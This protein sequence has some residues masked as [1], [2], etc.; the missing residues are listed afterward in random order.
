MISVVYCT[1]KTSPEHKEH[2]IKSSGLHKK[3]EVIEIINNG[4]S[5]TKAYNRGLK[6]AN[7]NIV[8]FC[9][10]DITIE[11]KNWGEKLLKQLKN[12]PEY[13]I[14][15]VAGTKYLPQ[16]GRW[17]EKPQKMYGRVQHTH[18][19]KTWLSSY[20]DDLGLDLEQVVLVDGLFFAVDKT[21][22]KK[23][24]NEDVNGFHFYD[25]NF[26]FE[27]YLEDVKI[28]VTTIV[29]VN[30]KSIGMTN[31]E[32]ENNRVEFAEKFKEK[33]PVNIKRVL[34]KREK[35]KILIGCLN[36]TNYT[37]SELYVFELAKA[38]VKENCEVTV[39]S[40]IGNPMSSLA[41]RHG[42][43]LATLQE[44][45]GFRLG[46]GKWELIGPQG[47]VIS[48]PNTLYKL[49][50]VNFD[51]V[52]LNHKPVTEHLLRLYPNTPTI[53]SIHSEVINLEEPVISEQIKK[54]IAIRPE[55]K[56]FITNNFQITTE[57]VDV[58]Y[59]P[60]D[61]TKFKP[62]QSNKKKNKKVTLFVGTIDYLR[63]NAIIDLIN[64]TKESDGELW[65]V[66]KKYDN[67]LDGLILGHDHVKYFEPTFNVE[68]Y[69]NECDETAGILL[70]RTTIEG[71]LCGK[72]GWIYDVDNQ[73]N[74]K[75]KKLYD[76]PDDIDKFKSENVANQIIEIYKSLLD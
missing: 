58:I 52:H 13:G 63:K 21:K 23:I 41:Q 60:I 20:S 14:V 38:L 64:T 36:F 31:D 54:Y 76:V 18:E 48:Q 44:P 73:G 45:P 75:S 34:R 17:W 3:L 28:G 29:R 59:N 71:W 46:D 26:C 32:W 25:V 62:V 22:I 5:L 4:E 40:N 49:S 74:V 43:K 2:L 56:D 51:V 65:I 47:K 39:C 67:M 53:C 33:L 55:I 30:H 37:G 6:Q 10:D 69:V 16:S 61:S 42:I 57:M 68:K 11:T 50:D 72:K 1:R 35:L 70:G 27:N 9:H 8:I 24:F 7:N 12:N 15:G 19:G 66:G